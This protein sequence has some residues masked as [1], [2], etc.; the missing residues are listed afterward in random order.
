MC[1]RRCGPRHGA[2]ERIT[3]ESID[4]IRQRR[5]I[6]CGGSKFDELFARGQVPSRLPT[7]GHYD[8]QRPTRGVY[9]PTLRAEGAEPRIS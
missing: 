4:P 2:V 6:R 9:P 1:L 7:R 3:V 8:R 5:A